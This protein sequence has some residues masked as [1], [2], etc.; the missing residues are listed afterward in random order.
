MHPIGVAMCVVGGSFAILGAVKNW[1]WFFLWPPAPIFVRLLTR[2]GARV[3]YGLL[4]IFV[5]AGGILAGL[6]MIE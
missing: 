5:I 6:G 4:G 3:F 1:N 2:G